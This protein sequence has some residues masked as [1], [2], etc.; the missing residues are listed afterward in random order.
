MNE[1]RRFRVGANRVVTLPLAIKPGPGRKNL[2]FLGG[3]EFELEV[4]KCNAE[5]RYLAGRLRAGDLEELTGKVAASAGM[6]ADGTTMD[7][8]TPS[9]AKSPSEVSVTTGGAPVEAKE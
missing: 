9:R 3:E 2:R 7:N 8:V 5:Q 4:A 6:L 1:T